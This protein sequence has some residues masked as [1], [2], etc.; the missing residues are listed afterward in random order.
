MKTPEERIAILETEIRAVHENMR[1]IK[2]SL[3]AL[4]TIAQTG[5]GVFRT[6]LFIGGSVGWLFGIVMGILSFLRNWH[7][8]P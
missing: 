5:N 1:E 3:K 6:V 2:A 7:G 8:N 4:E